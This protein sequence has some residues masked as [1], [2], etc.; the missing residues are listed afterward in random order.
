MIKGLA[1]VRLSRHHSD[2]HMGFHANHTISPANERQSRTRPLRRDVLEV[3][4]CTGIVHLK[5]CF[6]GSFNV[7][8]LD[9]PAEIEQTL[10]L[11][12]P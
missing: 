12:F 2:N 11:Y 6:N 3:Q 9:R 5:K 7:A 1:K 10:L 8:E 4:G